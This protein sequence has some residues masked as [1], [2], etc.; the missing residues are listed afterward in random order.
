MYF[1]R[2]PGKPESSSAAPD[3]GS[4]DPPQMGTSE[5]QQPELSKS[6][7]LDHYLVSPA[8]D[9]S[10][11]HFLASPESD[12]SA[13]D[14]LVSADAEWGSSPSA[15]SGELSVNDEEFSEQGSQQAQVLASH[16]R[17]TAQGQGCRK[18]GPEGVARSG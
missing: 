3:H 7:S 9:A 4:M 2:F 18:R 17:P 14:S 8:S 5:I 15:S 6:P 13:D 12:A 16:F 10:L 1:E 11:D